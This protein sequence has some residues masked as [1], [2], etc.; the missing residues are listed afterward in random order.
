[1]GDVEPDRVVWKKA[2]ELYLRAFQE[3]STPTEKK[4]LKRLLA[5]PISDDLTQ[6]LFEYNSFLRGLGR[7]S[8]SKF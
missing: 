2:H 6:E 3:P 7:M 1:M 8:L 4:K 5:H